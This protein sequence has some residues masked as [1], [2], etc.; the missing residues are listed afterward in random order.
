[1]SLRVAFV[2]R[3]YFPDDPRLA[4]QAGVQIGRAHV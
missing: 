2:S 4:R 1:M 3:S